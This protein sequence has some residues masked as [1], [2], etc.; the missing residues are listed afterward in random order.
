MNEIAPQNPLMLPIQYNGQVYI[1]SQRLHAEYKNNDGSKYRQLKDFNRLIRSIEAYQNYVDNKDIV[2]LTWQ[3][4]KGTSAEFAPV[5]ESTG[6][7]PLMLINATM[8]LALSHHLDDE[9]SKTISVAINTQ[10]AEAAKQSLISP[11][12]EFKAALMV[13]KLIGFKGNQAVM[14][15]NRAVVKVTGTNLLEVL[16]AELKAETKQILLTATDIGV[17]LGMSAIKVN[18][19]LEVEGFMQSFRGADNKLIWQLTDKGK[20]YAEVLDTGK[21]RS[22]GTPVKQIKW[23]DSIV[24][25]IVIA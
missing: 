18:A 6:Y 9:I 25:Q 16:D 21:K 14:A 3:E 15:A 12:K 5:F 11:S 4:V 23:L 1:T 22:D 19:L 24:D 13:A 2:E 7:K 10:A 17:K 20:N 8:Q